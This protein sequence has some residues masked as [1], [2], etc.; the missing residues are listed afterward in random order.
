MVTDYVRNYEAQN[1]GNTPSPC[2]RFSKGGKMARSTG[3][4]R[5]QQIFP[6]TRPLLLNGPLLARSWDCA[7]RHVSLCPSSRLTRQPLKSTNSFAPIQVVACGFGI[8]NRSHH[9]RLLHLEFRFIDC[10][11]KVEMEANASRAALK[12]DQLLQR[13]KAE[14]PSEG[15][16]ARAV[17]R[18]QSIGRGSSMGRTR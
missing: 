16:S 7:R 18:L 1:G 2:E 13:M 9:K 11:G 3:G 15:S 6:R 5:A 14:M 8:T 17:I 4:L 10:P 12:F